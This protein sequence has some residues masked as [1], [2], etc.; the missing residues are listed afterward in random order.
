MENCS[1][2][3]TLPEPL[4][5]T[6]KFIVSTPLNHT[7]GKIKDIFDGHGHPYSMK[8]AELL[9]STISA[10]G[11]K[12]LADDLESNLSDA[13]LQDVQSLWMEDD[14]ELKMSDLSRMSSL[15]NLIAKVEGDWLIQIL[16]EERLYDVFQPIVLAEDPSQIH[17]YECLL[18][19]ES[20]DGETI[21]PGRIFGTAQKS[22]LLFQLDR[23]ARI[24]AVKNARNIPVNKKLFINFMPTSI[25]DA[26]YCLQTTMEA[27]SEYDIRKEQLVFEVVETEEIKDREGLIE[28]LNYYRNEGVA[29]ALD[30]LGAGY[31]SLNLLK[32][33]NP[34]YIKLDLELVQSVEEN[35]LQAQ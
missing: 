2:C 34:D 12:T 17:G 1:R 20:T 10:E 26:E 33:L 15:E 22:D 19:A 18:R 7:L 21:S 32:N 9:Y 11:L 14:L 16:R 27:V 4:E 35:E 31:S 24:E 13:E 6:G 8:D 25:Y 30:D 23:Q 5:G 28:I 29:V 3:E